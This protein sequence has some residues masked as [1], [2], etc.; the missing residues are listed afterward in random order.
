MADPPPPLS[1]AVIYDGIHKRHETGPGHPES[2]MRCEA[3]MARLAE[4]DFADRLT[5]LPAREATEDELLACHSASYLATARRDVESGR[6][7]LSTGDTTICG[8]SLAA[9]LVSAGGVL[10]ATEAVL[11]GRVRNAFCA[12]R[13]PGHHATR[14]RGM[15]FCLFNNIAL[16]ARFAQKLDGAIE[17]V[18]IADWDLH[19]G[20]GTQ[21]IFYDDPSVFY[22]ST[23]QWPMY[24]GTG[25]PGETGR[26]EG[27]GTTLNCPF[28][29]GAGGEQIRRAFTDELLPAAERFDPDL[30][31]ISAGFDSRIGDPFGGLLLTDA[32]FAELTHLLLDLADRHAGGRVVSVLEGGYSLTGLAAAAEAHVR[33][34]CA[35]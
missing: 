5:Y 13:P 34:L 15:G 19:H 33:A 25:L 11:Q 26:G 1:T 16:A 7:E 28:G 23:H 2:P 18:L 21:D 6:G 4:C 31:L 9:A 14:D 3:I 8:A 27:K 12:V 10:A 24:P 22:F 35:I 17:R 20:N 30:V 29:A 32:D